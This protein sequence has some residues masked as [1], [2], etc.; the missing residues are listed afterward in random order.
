MLELLG[1]E[2]L[3]S[4]GFVPQELLHLQQDRRRQLRKNLH[5]QKVDSSE[6]LFVFQSSNVSAS[7]HVCVCVRARADADLDGSDVFGELLGSGGSQQDGAH[8]VVPQAPG[9]GGA[10]Q[11]SG[12]PGSSCCCLTFDPAPAVPMASW[13]SVHPRR[14]ASACSSFSFSC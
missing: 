4:V 12:P 1:P 9:C 10:E 3:P 13:G 14:S 11:R 6:E 5:G 2:L 8:P 7:V